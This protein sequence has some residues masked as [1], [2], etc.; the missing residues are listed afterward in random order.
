MQ[1]NH[2][3]QYVRLEVCHKGLLAV[4]DR[5]AR[6]Q[7]RQFYQNAAHIWESLDKEMVYCRRFDK[8]TP[9]YTELLRQYN[10]AI[11]TFDEWHLM[12][13]LSY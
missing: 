3:A 12:A 2:T 4:P 1:A 7:L 10:N 6:R 9:L 11:K 13:A 5:T 8:L